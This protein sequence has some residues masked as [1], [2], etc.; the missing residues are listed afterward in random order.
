MIASKQQ[1]PKGLLSRELDKAL[2]N[3]ERQE[4]AEAG[5]QE[6]LLQGAK[7][8]ASDIGVKRAYE[9]ICR[10]GCSCHHMRR[11]PNFSGKIVCGRC[12]K[13]CPKC[14]ELIFKCDR[15]YWDL[16]LRKCDAQ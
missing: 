4:A 10:W 16:H 9:V 2:R 15:A 13:P 1:F 12:Q 11:Q 5:R 6:I 7:A 8:I 3:L 14:G